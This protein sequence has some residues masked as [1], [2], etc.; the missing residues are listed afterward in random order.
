MPYQYSTAQV[1]S[2]HP[3]SGAG[4]IFFLSIP[5]FYF[6]VSSW[7]LFSPIFPKRCESMQ[8]DIGQTHLHVA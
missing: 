3:L 5:A 4:R 8:S 1:R 6:H 7:Q 2:R